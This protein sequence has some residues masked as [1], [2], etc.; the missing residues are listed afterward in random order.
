MARVDSFL[1]LTVKQR[2]SDL[3]LMSGEAPRI[4]LHGELYPVKYRELTI[5]ETMELLTEIMAADTRDTFAARCGVDFAYEVAGLSRFRVSVFRHLGGVGAVFRTIPNVI[6]SLDDLGMPPV[7]QNLGARKRGLLL[8]VG[9]TGSGKSTT[10]AALI[11]QINLT[12]KAHIITIEDPVEFV[13][14]RQS[15]LVS[16]REVGTHTKSFALALRAILREDPNV[17]LVGE[18]RDLETVSLAVSAAETGVLV[19]ATL[20]TNGAAATVDRIVNLF[21]G[22]EQSRIRNMLSTS[23]CGI[24]SQH[25]LK[26]ADGKGRVPAVEV[27]INNAAVGNLVR[28]GKSKQLQTVMQTGALQ[29]MQ[30]IDQSLQ[31]LL[32]AKLISGTEAYAKAANKQAFEKLRDGEEAACA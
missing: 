21:P 9:A 8:V 10:L 14:R 18:L 22:S 30:T 28:E 31:K 29:G 32:D 4:R 15:S 19:L 26:R 24:V 16:Q 1:E 20:H 27:L 23:L 7:L 5:T 6:P 13:H 2:A 12:R 25:L 17:V 3:H 11:H